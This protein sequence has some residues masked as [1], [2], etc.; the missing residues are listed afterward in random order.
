MALPAA[1]FCALADHLLAL[2]FPE[3]AERPLRNAD[4]VAA[5][6]CTCSRPSWPTC[7]GP[8]AP[9]RGGRCAG[10]RASTTQLPAL[11]AALL[12]DASAI[13]ASRPRRPGPGRNHQL[14]TRASTPR[15]CTGWPT[16]CTGAGCR[17]LPRLLSEYAHQRTGID[18]H[19]GASIGPSFC[20]DHGTGLVIGETPLSGPTSRYYQGVTLGRA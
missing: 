6:P 8:V 2:L 5:E 14:R 12:L 16:P 19:P 17:A 18:I 20:I 13:V 15:P 7:S 11:R 3:R 10:R 9:A 1:G 4:A